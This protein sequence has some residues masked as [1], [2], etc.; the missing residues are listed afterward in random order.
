METLERI[1]LWLGVEDYT[2]LWQAIAEAQPDTESRSIDEDRARPQTIARRAIESLLT[3]GLIELFVCPEP[4]SNE[5]AQIVPPARTTE[6]LD[7]E[8]SWTVPEE[9]GES[10]RFATTDRGFLKY[11]E[12]T[13]WMPDRRRIE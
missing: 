12:V 8:T 4:L 9:G 1:L 5:T 7:Q 11:R 3:E 13:G 6:I 10:V 2:G